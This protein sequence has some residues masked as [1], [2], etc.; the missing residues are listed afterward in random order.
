MD[1][2]SPGCLPTLSLVNLQ[3]CVSSTWPTNATLG[4]GPGISYS[5]MT[6]SIPFTLTHFHANST[7]TSP[8]QVFLLS[9]DQY[10]QLHIQ[11]LHFINIFKLNTF[12]TEV[13]DLSLTVPPS[14]FP[15]P[16]P[17]TQLFLLEIQK[18][19]TFTTCT[20][21]ISK[22]FSSGLQNVALICP[23]SHLD[24]HPPLCPPP[25]SLSHYHLSPTT[26]Q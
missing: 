13:L 3:D 23:V 18:S 19:F 25:C 7:F 2:H 26:L 1:L 5:L 4:L 17:S 6:R 11:H 16:K 15:I 22:S 9:L 24:C 12:K 8:D 21:S 20:Q 14:M 10:S